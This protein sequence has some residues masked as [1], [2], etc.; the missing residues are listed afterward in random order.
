MFVVINK[1]G[2]HIGNEGVAH[3]AKNRWKAIKIVQL[4]R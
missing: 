1:E 3:L 2:N 4:G